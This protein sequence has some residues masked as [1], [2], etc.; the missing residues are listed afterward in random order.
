METAF[1]E[2][3]D[4]DNF[5]VFIRDLSSSV[6]TNLKHMIEDSGKEYSNKNKTDT[7][8]KK[9]KKQNIII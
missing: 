5:N 2:E 6:H 9:M 3:L 7:K 4:T 1:W 8:T